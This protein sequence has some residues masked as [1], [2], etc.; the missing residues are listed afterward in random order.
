MK[1]TEALASLYQ[2]IH[3]TSGPVDAKY[4]L[5]DTMFKIITD[6][7]N[8]GIPVTAHAIEERIVKFTHDFMRTTHRKT[9]AA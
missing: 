5:S 8:E 4:M 9:E 6:L 1:S 7:H 3:Q 2:V